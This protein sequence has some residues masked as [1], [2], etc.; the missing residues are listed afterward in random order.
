MI[1]TVDLETDDFDALNAA[2]V[3]ILGELER[4][5]IL[6]EAEQ[7]V[8]QINTDVQQALGRKPGDPWEQPLGVHDAYPYGWESTDEGKLWESTVSGN[9]WKPGVSGWREVVEGGGYPDFVQPTG[10]HDAYNKDEIVRF[11]GGL[12]MSNM[13]G[14]V[15][16]PADYP[17]GW[18]LIE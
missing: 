16:S 15:W 10:Q 13:N 9:V 4:R 12:F 17:A 8:D 3:Q 2:A 11:E 5:R 6:E 7:Q 18:T 1:I 14:N